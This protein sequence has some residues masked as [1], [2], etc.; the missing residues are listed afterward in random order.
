[1]SQRV[2]GIK[3]ITEHAGATTLVY[4]LKAHVE[5]LYRVRAVEID[6]H[7]F[8]FF[9]D[10]SLESVN[11]YELQNYLDRNSD[12]EVILVDMGENNLEQYCTD[13][14]Y[15]IEPGIVQLNRLIREDNRIFKNLQGKKI[16]LNRSVLSQN[17]VSDFERESGSKVFYNMPN[18]DDKD[19]NNKEIR[20]LLIALGFTRFSDDT[21]SSFGIFH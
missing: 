15:L 8:D 18:V 4:L 7:D 11:N 3:N 10:N 9:N 6:K 2:L 21:K 20:N 16:V 12:S 17:D 13:M 19:T 1:M 14:I 5:E